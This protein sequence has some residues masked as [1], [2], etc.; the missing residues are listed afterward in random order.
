MHRLKSSKISSSSFHRFFWIPNHQNHSN[1]IPMLL[2]AHQG[3]THQYLCNHFCLLKNSNL[4]KYKNNSDRMVPLHRQSYRNFDKYPFKSVIHPILLNQNQD[5]IHSFHSTAH[6]LQ[7]QIHNE[8][9]FSFYHH[10][11]I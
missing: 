11:I 3:H 9:M 10:L 7:G 2:Q 6:C 1:S 4:G 8:D 5:Q